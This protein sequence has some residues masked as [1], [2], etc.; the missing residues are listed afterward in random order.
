MAKN[1]SI[2]DT[3]NNYVLDID[4]EVQ[5]SAWEEKLE[6]LTD[7]SIKVAKEALHKI[8]LTKY[9]DHIE[10]SIILTDNSSIQKL[11]LQ[12]RGKDKA[13]NTLS[14][15]AQDIKVN[16]LELFKFQD[17]FIMLGDIIFAHKI[18][19]DEALNQ[20]KLFNNHFAHLLIHGILHLL[21]YDHQSEKEAMI[22]ENIETEILSTLSIKSPYEAS[23][24]EHK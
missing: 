12:Y 23:S 14:F 1:F 2:T 3:N 9:V 21:G 5:D 7:W 24:S 19:E 17:K 10:L 20:G 13:T 22:M 16:Q 8:G 4:F 6:N 15:P 18:V 11:N